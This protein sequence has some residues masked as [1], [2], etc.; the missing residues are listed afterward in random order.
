MVLSAIYFLGFS[1]FWVFL[2]FFLVFFF[3]SFGFGGRMGS[4]F[5]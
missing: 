2:G 3:G 1:G 5:V 4:A